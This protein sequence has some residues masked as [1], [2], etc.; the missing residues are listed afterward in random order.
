MASNYIGHTIGLFKSFQSH[1][2]KY[3]HRPHGEMKNHGVKCEE[4]WGPVLLHQGDP[5]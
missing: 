1:P 2:I 5:V 3:M 4:V